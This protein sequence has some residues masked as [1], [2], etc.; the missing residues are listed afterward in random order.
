MSQ[1]GIGLLHVYTPLFTVVSQMKE[2]Y[3]LV[4]WSLEAALGRG[5]EVTLL[6]GCRSSKRIPPTVPQCQYVHYSVLGS[7]GRYV[8]F[9]PRSVRSRGTLCPRNVRPGCA[10][11]CPQCSSLGLPKTARSQREEAG[12]DSRNL[13]LR[14]RRDSSRDRKSRD[15]SPM[16]PRLVRRW[17]P[18][19]PS[20]SNPPIC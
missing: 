19:H 11:I 16:A 15:D 9:R 10:L 6:F 8:L 13:Q 20:S 1:Y 5:L 4:G 14:G 18:R 3:W 17:R 7:R 12:G 2:S